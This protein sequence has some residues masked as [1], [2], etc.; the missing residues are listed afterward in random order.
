[1]FQLETTRILSEAY[2]DAMDNKEAI[3]GD[4]AKEVR[5][6]YFVCLYHNVTSLCFLFSAT[7]IKSH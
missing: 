6:V 1:M 2:Q 3:S 4:D 5:P 7:N